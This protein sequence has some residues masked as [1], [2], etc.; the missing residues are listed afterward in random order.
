MK[1]GHQV[2][3]R[4]L[5]YVS[6]LL[7]CIGLVMIFVV[8]PQLSLARNISY[9][10]DLIT[11]SAPGRAAN[12]TFSFITDV[13]IPAR[14]YIDITIPDDFTLDASSTLFS[15]LRNVELSVNGIVRDVGTVTSATD[16][17]V[18][19]NAVSPASIR[20]TLND[21]AGIAL[22][23]SVVIKIGNHTSRREAGYTEYSTTTGTTTVPADSKPITNG[24]VSGTYQIPLSIHNNVGD[25][26]ASAG[27]LIAVAEQVG[28]GPV[29]TRE[30]IPPLR[31]NGAPTG[32][33][34]G[35]TFA[36]EVTLEV[37]E[38]S[39][40][41]YSFTPGVDYSDMTGVFGNISRIYQTFILQ[42]Q[43]NTQYDIYVRCM[44][45]ENNINPDDYLITFKIDPRPTGQST[46]NGSSGGDGSGTGSAGNGSAS[47]TGTVSGSSTNP[48]TSTGSGSGSVSG[49]GGTGGGSGG[50]TGGGSGGGGGGGTESVSDTFRSG[51][52]QVSISGLTSPRAKITALV[53][54]KIGATSV[55][56]GNG[57]YTVT[58]DKIARGVYTFGV[59]A[60]DQSSTKSTTFSTSFT[61]S[62]ARTSA[63]SN[64]NLAPTVTATPNP[65]TPGQTLTLSGYTF[66][67]ASVVLENEKDKSP[68][69]RKSYTATANNSGA[70]SVAVDTTGY[71]AGTY[72]ARANASLASGIQTSF[73]QYTTY[74]IGQAVASGNNSDLNRDGKVNLTDFS[75]LLYWWNTAG[76]DS[77]PPADIS[78][79]GKVN[80]TDFS[81]L[82]FN[83]TG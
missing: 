12:H 40:C 55:A 15:P 82:L 50:G 21:T 57:V 29:D 41:R 83:W 53:D 39:L 34:S 25:E 33:L 17:A 37:N 77:N 65:V 11:S 59:Y 75:I 58:I 63:L 26:L 42:V 28:V 67:N 69:S 60:T 9:Y 79:D 46:T 71:A 20:Y 6:G 27:F 8:A 44:D 78:S 2:W 68:S 22:G 74:G 38:F 36:V 5:P 49:N 64:I 1:L 10:S 7:V 16:D 31:F 80:L 14:S 30:S 48:E 4:F 51:D 3:E 76:G 23:S 19:I 54:G 56:D 70:W 73:S 13:D 35:T 81:I 61:V 72:K 18:T 43:P 45:D 47:T 32:T 66:P 24:S 62:G 52:G